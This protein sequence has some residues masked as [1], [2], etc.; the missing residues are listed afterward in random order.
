MRTL[1]ALLVVAGVAAPLSAQQ[2]AA[3]SAPASADSNPLAKLVGGLKF[4]SIGPAVTSGRI[5]DVAVDPTNKKVWYVAAAAGGV[6]KSTN[7]GTSFTPVFESE[8]S[9]SIGAIAIDPRTPSTVWVGTGENNAQRVVAYGDGIYKSIDGGKSWKNMG[10]KASE[11]IARILIDPRDPNVVYVAAQGP[12]WSKGGERGVYKT[13][14]GGKSWTRILQVN[15][16]TGANDIQLDP[17]NPDILIASTWQRQRRTCCFVAGGPGSGIHRSLDGG[18]TWTKSQSGLPSGDLGRIGLSVSPADPSFVYAVV[19]AANARGG[20]FRSRD[21]GASWEKMSSYQSGGNYYNEVF[22][23]PKNPDRVYAVDVMLQVS[24]DGGKTFGRVGEL[25]KH[26]DNHSVWIDPDDTEHL[27]VGCDGGVY[28][29]FDRGR[30]WRFAANLPLSQFYRVFADDVKPF[31]RVFGGA[32]DNFSIGGPS[33]TRTINGIRNADWFITSGGD[34]FGSVVDWKDP[35]TVYAQSQFGN[36]SRFNLATG[37][38]MGIQPEDVAGGPGLRWNWDSPLLV[39]PHA[40]NRLYFAADRVMRSDDRGDSWKAISPDISRNLDR[41]GITMMD[42]V[43]SVDAVARNQSTTLFGNA[44]ALTESTRREGLLI[45]GTNDGRVSVTENGGESWRTIDRFPTVPE[46]TYVSRVVASQHDANTIYATFNNHQSGDFTPYVLRSTDLGRTWTSITANLPARGSVWV[47]AED[48]VDPKLLFV[49]TDFGVFVTLDGG[50]K[51]TPLKAGL[52]TIQVRDIAIQPRMNDLV[53]GTFG[54]GFYILD[55]YSPLRSMGA[56]TTAATLYPTRTAYLYS[57]S[58]PLGLPGASFQ[59]HGHYMAEN[60]PYGAV[61]SYRLRDALRS[62]KATR[63]EADAA[64]AKKGADA[65]FPSWGALK[66]EDREEDPAIVVEVSDAS[67]ARVRRFTGPTAAGVHRVVWDLNYQPANPVNGPGYQ[68]DPEFPFSSPPPA[69]TALP[70]RYT[71]RLYARVDGAMTPLGEPVPLVVENA[72][73]PGARARP[74][75]AAT[76]AT[77]LRTAELQ[78]AVLGASALIDETMARLRFLKRAIDETPSADSALIRQARVVE[79]RLRDAQEALRGD[80]TKDRRAEHSPTS[81]QG[82]LQGA[83]GQSWGSTLEAATPA[84]LAQVEIVR[85][86]FGRVYA[87][88]RAVLDVELKALEAAAD[89][90]GV[91]WT[92]GRAPVVPR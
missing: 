58:A 32:Q 82:R 81:L 88:L 67:G 49:G 40:S 42:R 79:D 66:A 25:L 31:Y 54:R 38:V 92:S 85:A 90:A 23:D 69:P 80:N 17:R 6:W 87:Q 18:K 22:A 63:Q 51:W 4:R 26:V 48:H 86:E 46:T 61:I 2:P 52:P 13:T 57:Q 50:A 16:W 73:A 3:S 72:D 68:A 10:L 62:R 76:L 84:Q 45:V 11:H 29:S 89:K 74:Q 83:I 8:G 43:Q 36:L 91:P 12:L 21:G 59:G 19:D 56:S 9:F 7:A 53:L 37:D 75:T 33:R 1:S 71:V 15:D 14:D 5:A 24:H 35:N 27:I 44:T 70:G 28:E 39:S 30:T 41:T 65:I 55:D 34:G 47:L 77:D 64:A 20:L 78:R 60:P